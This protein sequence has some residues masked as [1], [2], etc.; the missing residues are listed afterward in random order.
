MCSS[1]ISS[2]NLPIEVADASPRPCD[3]AP[4]TK[5]AP[6]TSDIPPVRKVPDKDP[7]KAATGTI[8]TPVCTAATKLRHPRGWTLFLDLDG[9]LADFDEGVRAVFHASP[10]TLAPSRMWPALARVPGGFFSSLPLM[11]DA[12]ELWG[13]CTAYDPT[14]LTGLP[15]GAWAEPQKR[16]WCARNLGDR[17]KV[18]TCLAR[19]KAKFCKRGESVLVDDREEN[20][21]AW[22]R[23]GGLFVLHTSAARSIRRLR[24][25]GFA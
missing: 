18:I 11:H 13:H 7:T 4:P 24:E 21:G 10:A 9:V 6:Q 16:E 22:E 25:L 20:R 17:V 3:R 23:A 5:E 15:M 8:P 14:I 2:R 19:E 12:A 1:E